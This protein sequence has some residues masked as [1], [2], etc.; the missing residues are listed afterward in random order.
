CGTAAVNSI[1]NQEKLLKDTAQIFKIGDSEVPKTAERFF[2]EWKQFQKEKEKLRKQLID[3]EKIHLLENA[4]I[5]NNLKLIIET[6]P[7]KSSEDLIELAGA[8]IKEDPSI[9][10][11][12]GGINGKIS[13]I[14]MLGAQAIKKGLHAGNLVHDITQ[15]V[16]GGGGGN[17]DLGQGGGIPKLRLKDFKDVVLSK[18]LKDIKNS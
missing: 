3:I 10:V 1:Q 2:K 7:E 16:G 18:I 8:L 6:F 14:I 5:K 12:L 13:L 17:P 4:S 11:V 9:V 15:E